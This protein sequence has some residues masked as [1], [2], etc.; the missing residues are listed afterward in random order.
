MKQQDE[1]SGVIFW[2]GVIDEICCHSVHLYI[3]S[4]HLKLC[5]HAPSCR[6]DH[7]LLSTTFFASCFASSASAFIRF[8]L[9]FRISILSSCFICPSAS[10][11][12]QQEIV[13]N[14][15]GE[16]IPRISSHEWSTL[17]TGLPSPDV[18]PA[19]RAEAIKTPTVRPN[20]QLRSRYEVRGSLPCAHIRACTS[21]EISVGSAGQSHAGLTYFLRE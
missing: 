19:T 1:M 7:F 16:R 9:P 15:G 4:K 12:G 2:C 8:S 5:V 6:P 10:V 13:T 21:Y 3:A 17:S 11:P 14:D 18:V 20:Y